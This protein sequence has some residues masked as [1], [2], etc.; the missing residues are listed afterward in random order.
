[1][2]D[3]GALALLPALGV[4]ALAAALIMALRRRSR[5]RQAAVRIDGLLQELARRRAEVRDAE[6]ERSRFLAAFSHD[7][8]QP[9]QAVNLYL[10]GIERGLAA[11]G[12]EAAE[13][14]RAL[15]SLLRLKQGIGYMNEVFDSVLDISRLDSGVLAVGAERVH[16]QSFCERL[17]RQHQRVA[18]DLGLAL[19]LRAD[20]MGRACA[21]TDP[22]LLERILRNFI[23][24]ALRYTRRGGIRVRISERDGRCRIA[25]V[26]TG[27]GI[28]AGMRRKIFEE[29]NRGDSAAM[30]EQGVG[31]G[32]SIARRLAGRIGASVSVRSHVGLGSVFAI[33]L[34]LCT[35]GP[36]EAEARAMQEERLLRGVLTE[37]VVRPP[38]NTLLVCLDGDP[39]VAHALGLIAPGLGVEVLA[40]ASSAEAIR[41]LARI[42]R[43]PSVLL[44]DARLPSEPAM[45]AVMRI[46]EEFN[47]EFPLILCSDEPLLAEPDPGRGARVSVLIRPFG[48]ERLREAINRSLSRLK[49]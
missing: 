48:A 22:R 44:V 14:A 45:Q 21:D 25:V 9:M 38:A 4:P 47:A 24:N 8:K 49:S 33:D 34:P 20:D 17:L 6:L 27:S 32:L 11:A 5:L 37:V 10:D 43:V 35:H 12:M 15:E 23:S 13:R 46:N 31:L 28:A 2:V 26:D 7:L 40:A 29:F 19:Q 30:A 16:L 36:S 41:E 3:F 1:M 39:E 42:D 18:D